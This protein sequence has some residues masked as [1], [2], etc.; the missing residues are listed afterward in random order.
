M[1]KSIDPHT[2]LKARIVNARIIPAL[3]RMLRAAT[4]FKFE[5]AVFG[6]KSLSTLQRPQIFLEGWRENIVDQSQGLSVAPEDVLPAPERP[7]MPK[8]PAGIQKLS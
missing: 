4:G 2:A 6:I 3:A 8:A 7:L 5:K 1:A